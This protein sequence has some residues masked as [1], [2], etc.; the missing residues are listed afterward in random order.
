MTGKEFLARLFVE[1][2]CTE[3]LCTVEIAALR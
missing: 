2:D 1:A 3:K